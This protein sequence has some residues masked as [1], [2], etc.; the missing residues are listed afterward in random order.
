MAVGLRQPNSGSD[1]PESGASPR[2][3]AHPGWDLDGARVPERLRPGGGVQE[4]RSAA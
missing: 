3:G 2:R 1:E 4:A